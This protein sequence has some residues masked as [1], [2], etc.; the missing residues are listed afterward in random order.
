MINFMVHIMRRV[1]SMKNLKVLAL[2][3]VL[4]F[5]VAAL[6]ACGAKTET[7][8]EPTP[9]PTEQPAPAEEPT[10]AETGM[11]DGVY[12]AEQ[13]NYDDRGWKGFVE[14]EVKDGK[15]ATVKFDYINKDNALKSEDAGYNASMEKVTGTSPEKA[16]PQLS[17]ALVEKQDVAAVEAVAG[18]TSSS[19]DFTTLAAKALE[20]AK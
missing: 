19:T 14:I 2:V 11:K 8:A 7:P 16:F 3:M 5:A 17:D 6:T 1:I 18:A 4:V 10:P 13:D 9:A 15:I 20:Q 12:K